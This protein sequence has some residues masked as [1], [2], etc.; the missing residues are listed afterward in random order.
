MKIT[1][2]LL[3]YVK[4]KVDREFNEEVIKT[5]FEKMANCTENMGNIHKE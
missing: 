5:H 1:D 2:D 4:E 3:N